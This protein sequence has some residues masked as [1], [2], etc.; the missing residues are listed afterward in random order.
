MTDKHRFAGRTAWIV[1][2]SSGIGAALAAELAGRGARV[3]ISARRKSALAAVADGEMAVV[4]VDVTD[5]AALAGAA[6]RVRDELG[7]IDMV[8]Y[9]AGFWEQMDLSD[10]DCDVF[11]RHVEINVLG[12]NNCLG[13]VLPHM[14]KAGSGHLVGVA[15]V[16]GYRGI[17]GAE[18]Y[19]A[20][21]A[22][23][24]NMLEALRTSAAPHGI[25]VTTVCPGFVRT[26][27]TAKNA[28]P[29]P[30]M[31]DAQTAARSI[32]NGVERG[33]MEIVFPLPMAVA[34]KIA[35]LLPVRVWAAAMRRVTK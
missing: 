3:A 13:A 23:Q 27:L 15:S 35:R 10:W 32:C 20:T 6:D 28:F 34:M 5:R 29:M 30:F 7:E 19:G 11:A 4:P 8:V 2:A 18:A 21:K 16:A 14:I 31:I 17:A 24:I 26:D 1:G 25:A 9:N 12:L 22:A 33:Q